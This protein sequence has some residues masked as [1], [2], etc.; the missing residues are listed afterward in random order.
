MKSSVLR[1]LAAIVIG[2][3]LVKF[4]ESAVVTITLI[5][6]G[7]FFIAGLVA[8]VS[9]FVGQRRAVLEERSTYDYELSWVVGAG[10]LIFGIVL[11]VMPR[12][13]LVALMYIL[14]GILI[15]CAVGQYV[16]LATAT[17]YGR[18]GLVWWMTPTLL[19]LIGILAIV[20]PNGVLTAPLF[21]IG[22]AMMVYGVVELV[23]AWMV[24]Q[25]F[26]RYAASLLVVDEPEEAEAEEIGETT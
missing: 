5:L 22:W 12:T 21:V 14:A 23:N 25:L 6:G 11:V 8:C 24:H 19:L 7:W 9:A 20:N 26:K 3:L 13:F 10:C 18:I 16:M 2:A 4:R 1:A 17:R 15:I